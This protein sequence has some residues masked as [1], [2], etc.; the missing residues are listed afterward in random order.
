[1]EYIFA[2]IIVLIGIFTNKKMSVSTRKIYYNF[3]LIYV[4]LLLGLRYGVGGD[5]IGYMS[6]YNRI[7]SF[8]DLLKTD[9]TKNRF[10]P[11]YLFICAF[12]KLFTNDFW[13][14]QTVMAAITNCCIF[15]FLYR[16][17]KNPFIG[18][19][20]YLILYCLYFSTEI[21]RESAAVGIFLMNYKN[22]ENKKW[23]KYYLLSLLSISFQYS[24]II[25]LFFPL[26]KYLRFNYLYVVLV[27]GFFAITPLVQNLNSMLTII[28]ISERVDSYITVA[29]NLNMNWRIG[30]FIRSGLPAIVALLLLKLYK[31]NSKFK[32]YALLQILFCAGAFA[33]P[34]M[35]A[36][37]SNFTCLFVVV[38]I[39]N[40]LVIKKIPISIRTL[41][42][43]FILLIQLNYYSR[44]A[45]RWVPY[46]S[47]F[48]P[49]NIHR[50]DNVSR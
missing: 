28:S 33:V 42:V 9:F 11:G 41:F 6:A 8:E 3:I 21:I 48:E 19:F 32:S 29:D 44:M 7:P 23:I 24:A 39:A 10:E 30:E 50:D 40:L 46:V 5:T 22:I 45:Y 26:I 16:N 15:I 12:C 34:I 31:Y 20:F 4:I 38:I 13:L 49:K 1:M 35:F 37:F 25:I 27:L 2:L 47:V 18:A 14:A 17:S 36:R 43:C